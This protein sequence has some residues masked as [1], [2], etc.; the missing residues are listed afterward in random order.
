[1]KKS[2]LILLIFTSQS[3]FAETK[4]IE[5]Q[6]LG[7]GNSYQD[8]V[9]NGLLTA[10]RQ[11]RGLEIG[12]ERNLKMEI[13]QIVDKSG[14]SHS[15]TTLSTKT[16]VY[17][18]SKGWI[19]S[20]SIVDVT[21]PKKEGTWKVKLNVIVPQFES[22]FK[23]D[24]R[25]KLAIMPFRINPNEFKLM[26]SNANATQISKRLAENITEQINLSQKFA[27][28]NRSYAN[29]MSLEKGLLSSDNVPPEEASRI[30]QMLGADIMLVGNIY[31]FK[32]EDE[33][34]N[35]YGAESHKLTDRIDLY[36]STVETATGKIINTNTKTYEQLRKKEDY[37][38][39]K[40]KDAVNDLLK[41]IA[42][43]ISKNVM[44]ELMPGSEVS[45]EVKPE[46]TTPPQRE[47]T[48]G[49]SEKPFKW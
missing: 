9:S 41:S 7:F 14:T 19:K 18:I 37:F 17:D 34:Q 25:L 45:E 12:S 36:F 49:S 11:V 27:I 47:T 46:K 40:D 16:D 29:E 31:E 43:L 26:D 20:F 8:A 10:V 30:G 23:Q 24:D 48:P 33:V 42:K 1:M 4:L 6:T 28:V 32:T 39:K 21:E 44:N 35:F 15:T 22:K 13:N 5:K 38:G 3:I 2:L